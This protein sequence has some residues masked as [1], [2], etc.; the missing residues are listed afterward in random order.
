M[1]HTV[2]GARPPAGAGRKIFS[3]HVLVSER[4]KTIRWPASALRYRQVSPGD[5][6]ERESVNVV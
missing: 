1:P 2:T 3:S 5:T 6:R 4:S